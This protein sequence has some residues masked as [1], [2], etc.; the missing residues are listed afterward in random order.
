MLMEDYVGWIK[1]CI[2]STRF[3]MI[4][5]GTPFGFFQSSKA[6]RQRDP[7]SPYL[8]VVAMEA[9]SCLVKRVREGEYLMGVKVK[10]KGGEGEE[11]SHFLFANDTLVFVRLPKIKWVD[12]VQELVSKLGCKE[13]KLPSTSLDLPLSAPF[14]SVMHPKKCQIEVRENSKGLPFGRWGVREKDASY[15]VA[16]GVHEEE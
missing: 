13:G 1:W 15:E 11:V 10:G 8:F 2:S 14:R 4:V 7:L 12:H 16:N 5:T 3:S 6:L 9:L